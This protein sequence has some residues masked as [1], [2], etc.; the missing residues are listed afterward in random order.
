M[1][2]KML[3]ASYKLKHY[4]VSINKHTGPSGVLAVKLTEAYEN[5]DLWSFG[6]DWVVLFSNYKRKKI[7][8]KLELKP[9]FLPMAFDVYQFGKICFAKFSE[10]N[11]LHIISACGHL[12]TI[13]ILNPQVEAV[14]KLHDETITWM[15][16]ISNHRI[17][18]TGIDGT[19]VV[20]SDQE[21]AAKIVIN[22]NLPVSCFDYSPD[23]KQIVT[24]SLT[25]VVTIHNV[26]DDFK[27][28]V[29]SKV[30]LTN[31][32]YV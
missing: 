6:S 1:Q 31:K 16:L 8:K 27:V 24:L 18:T 26:I 9:L 12:I 21:R 7:L 20:Y 17:L 32:T 30:E 29:P 13:N 5:A 4:D 10:N 11:L 23:R 19:L 15:Q 22:L 28:E 14:V 3:S 2:P 25:C